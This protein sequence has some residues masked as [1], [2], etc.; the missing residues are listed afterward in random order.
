[1]LMLGQCPEPHAGTDGVRIRVRAAGISPVDLKLRAGLSSLSKQLPLPHIPG[2][3]ASGVID[4]VGTGV[5]GVVIGSEVFGAVD[6]AKLGGATAEFAVLKF[7]AAKP[8]SMS[9][10][11]AG[12]AG[13]SIETA[14]RVLDKLGVTAGTTLLI[15][16]AAG[17]VGS[18]AVQLA[19]ALGARVIGTG[20]LESLAFIAQLG[21]IPVVFGEG[22]RERINALGIGSV[23]F[24][25][26]VAGAGTLPE[27]VAISGNASTVLTIADFAARGLGVGFSTGEMGGEPGGQHGLDHAAHLSQEA[28]FDIPIRATFP[29]AQASLAHATAQLGSSRGK[30][31]I[32]A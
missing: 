32:V 11:V 24:A 3:D 25:L 17:G 27:L 21:A 30:L 13:T 6:I 16:G 18:V 15:E 2:F 10:E 20:R 23:D 7:W 19:T 28:R 26:D 4:E 8:A 22:L 1:V 9:W 14:T 31:V 12:S 5:T 29:M